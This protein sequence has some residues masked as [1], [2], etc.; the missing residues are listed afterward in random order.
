MGETDFVLLWKEH[1]EKIDRTLAINKRL[2]A[3]LLTEKA[4]SSIRSIIRGKVA[5]IVAGL[6]WLMMLGVPL[7]FAILHYSHAANY[8]IG[9]IGAIFLINVKAVCDYIRHL[10]LLNRIR[11]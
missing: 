1:Y 6:V 7:A 10:A 8:F 2:L 9:S 5:G 4:N 11:Y 3:E